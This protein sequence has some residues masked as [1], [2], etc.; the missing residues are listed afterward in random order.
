MLNLARNL[1]QLSHSRSVWGNQSFVALSF[2]RSSTFARVTKAKTKTPATP[3]PST[4]EIVP[5]PAPVVKAEVNAKTAKA[6]KKEK[7]KV[8]VTTGPSLFV[9][10]LLHKMGALSTREIWDQYLKEKATNPE[11]KIRSLTFLKRNIIQPME[12]QGKIVRGG[13]NRQTRKF[14]GFKLVPELAFQSVDKEI[15]RGLKPRPD[16][17]LFRKEAAKEAAAKAE[18]VLEANVVK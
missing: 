5:T 18:V 13:Y 9:S 11:V 8:V 12:K 14:L 15:L 1:L 6:E 7:K 2:L 10:L 3:A 4:K 17:K 16:I